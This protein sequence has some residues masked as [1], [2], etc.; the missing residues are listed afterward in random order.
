MATS[1]SDGKSIRNYSTWLFMAL[2]GMNTLNPIGVPPETSRVSAKMAR[3]TC[4]SREAFG[5]QCLA[6]NQQAAPAL[7]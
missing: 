1:L 2:P 5:Q 4:T 6:A 7:T 3:S